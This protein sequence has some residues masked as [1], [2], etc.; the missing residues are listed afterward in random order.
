MPP[1]FSAAVAWR[2]R[3]PLMFEEAAR[4]TSLFLSR[5]RSNSWGTKRPPHCERCSRG[6]RAI[7]APRSDIF[8]LATQANANRKFDAQ[9]L[10]TAH[11]A[12]A[13]KTPAATA[14]RSRA[15]AVQGCWPPHGPALR[16]KGVGAYHLVEIPQP[17]TPPHRSFQPARNGHDRSRESIL[18]Y[19]RLLSTGSCLQVAQRPNFFSKSGTIGK[20]SLTLGSSLTARCFKILSSP[21][22]AWIAPSPR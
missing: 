8:G 7:P 6:G 5:L 13:L 12:Q 11:Q 3:S 22:A 15:L 1:V 21:A 18:A 19:I 16:G 14:D 17:Q 10:A 9:P 20:A 2:L 4:T